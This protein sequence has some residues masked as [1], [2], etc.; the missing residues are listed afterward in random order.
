MFLKA[1][2]EQGIQPE[3]VVESASTVEAAIDKLEQSYFDICFVDFMM[4]KQTG[5]EV[6][7]HFNHQKL[8]TAFVFLTAHAKK[9]WAFEAMELGAVDYL[10]KAKFDQFEFEKTLSYVLYRKMINLQLQREATRDHLTGLGNRRLFDEQLQTTLHRA[11][12]EGDRFAV[13]YLDVDGFKPVNDRYGHDIGDRLLQEISARI[14][15]TTRKSDIIARIGGD[16]FAAILVKLGQPEDT[17]IQAQKIQSRLVGSPFMIGGHEI[18]VGAS[19]GAA[20]FPDETSDVND[21]VRLADKR[22]Y[23]A[24]KQKKGVP[25]DIWR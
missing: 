12:R 17:L 2:I 7:R 13:L 25:G 20:V 18:H 11:V 15:E 22:M 9:K 4:G 14:V 5:L 23:E 19:I 8:D 24:K 6:L 10:I 16:E 3:F 1:M 21:L